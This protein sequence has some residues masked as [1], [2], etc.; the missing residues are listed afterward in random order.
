M[1]KEGT[2]EG[3]NSDSGVRTSQGGSDSVRVLM[4]EG[5]EDEERRQHSF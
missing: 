3:G 5:E 1:K 2:E 4:E